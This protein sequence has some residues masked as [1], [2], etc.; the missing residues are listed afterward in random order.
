MNQI[1]KQAVIAGASLVMMAI[2]AGFA[3]G[4][5]FPLFKQLTDMSLFP[6]MSGLF[7][8]MIAAF[9]VV[10]LLDVVVALKFRQL[11]LSVNRK[12]ANMQLALRVIYT[13]F[14]VASLVVLLTTKKDGSNLNVNIRHFQLIWMSGMVVFGVHLVVLSRLLCKTNGFPKFFTF[15]AL[16]A[17]YAYVATSIAQLV[18]PGYATYQ[19]TVESI[20]ALPMAAGELLLA[21][22][23]LILGGK[24]PFSREAL[25]DTAQ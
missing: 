25:A 10:A 20:L 4:Y 6:A 11:F 15:M 22:W 18:W 24:L 13:A 5:A 16:F 12:Q 7:Y 17:G 3:Y 2:V 1:R 9:G 8:S 19:P 21:F 14:L 23:L